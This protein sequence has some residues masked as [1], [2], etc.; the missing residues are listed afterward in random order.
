[1]AL[2]RARKG[3]IIVGNAQLLSFSKYWSMFLYDLKKRGLVFEGADFNKLVPTN[4]EFK[5]PGLEMINPE[6]EEKY[7]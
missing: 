2:T 7:M 1:M 6:M 4:L 5:E 3:M